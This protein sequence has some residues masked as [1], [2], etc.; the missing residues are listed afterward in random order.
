MG[1]F[2]HADKVRNAVRV[3]T[4]ARLV[5]LLA[6][7]T[8][9]QR[10]VATVGLAVIVFAVIKSLTWVALMLAGWLLCYFA[11]RDYERSQ[12]E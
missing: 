11:I 1:L 9:G 3:T 5:S 4:P 10:A 12:A 8:L 6:G 7:G 2:G